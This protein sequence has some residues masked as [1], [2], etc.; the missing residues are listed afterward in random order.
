MSGAKVLFPSWRYHATE[1]A[2]IVQTPEDEAALGPGWTDSPAT[3]P[4]PAPEPVIVEPEAAPA[5]MPI[6]AS[7]DAPVLAD[8]TTPSANPQA[9]ELWATSVAD[10]LLALKSV[11]A[12]ET[13]DKVRDYEQDNPKKPR[14]TVLDAIEKRR[15]DLTA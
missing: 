9:E 11:D 1:K 10:V 2:R 12:V 4:V 8:P 15:S 14:K 7:P 5:E 3:V 13:L 6:A